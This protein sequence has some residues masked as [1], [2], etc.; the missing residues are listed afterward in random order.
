M[1]AYSLSEQLF[2]FGAAAVPRAIGNRVHPG[3][4]IRGGLCSQDRLIA[5]VVSAETDGCPQL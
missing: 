1:G 2:E 3:S 4:G 5:L